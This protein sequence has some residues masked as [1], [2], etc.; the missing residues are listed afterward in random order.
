MKRYIVIAALLLVTIL[1]TSCSTAVPATQITEYRSDTV[2]G[3][4]TTSHFR[5]D[6]DELTEMPDVG[7]GLGDYALSHE[8]TMI[9]EPVELADG[10]LL[11]LSGGGKLN[12]DI[13]MLSF[14]NQYVDRY[15]DIEGKNG[16]VRYL[17]NAGSVHDGYNMVLFWSAK[18]QEGFYI[19][20]GFSGEIKCAV[21]YEFP[22]GSCY[23]SGYIDGDGTDFWTL[24]LPNS[25]YFRFINENICT[26]VTESTPESAE[27]TEITVQ[28]LS[29]ITR[30]QDIILKDT[31][32]IM[33]TYNIDGIQAEVG[34][35]EDYNI[36]VNFTPGDDDKRISIETGSEAKCEWLTST[37]GGENRFQGMFTLRDAISLK[38]YCFLR[39]SY[40]GAPYGNNDL[41]VFDAEQ[42]LLLDYTTL[43][44]IYY[45]EEVEAVFT[46]KGDVCSYSIPS[47]GI[48]QD[49]EFG[50]FGDSWLKELSR[51]AEGDEFVMDV[52]L[53]LRNIDYINVTDNKISA[54]R[55]VFTVDD[56]WE[57]ERD[58]W[59]YAE[60][61][62]DIY[63]ETIYE[64]Q[65]NV[66][67]PVK[68]VGMPLSVYIDRF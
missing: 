52:T 3:G 1:L 34:Y 14:E 27:N 30:P 11:D 4:D 21:L 60:W 64:M 38:K 18:Q 67:T 49:L 28:K 59:L 51:D 36:F 53:H 32:K 46:K 19:V 15:I 13:G 63:I 57:S 39:F 8:N 7:S 41:Y 47:Y 20:K 2:I 9:F 40:V 62:P 55:V 37:V 5:Y 65:N 33:E 56:K 35:D 22:D 25:N 16:K 12:V 68:Y 31:A 6:F 17:K 45:T 50:S 58:K 10:W 43:S 29:K 66:L 26:K 23:L 48:E 44:N 61:I 24:E 54:T 42:G